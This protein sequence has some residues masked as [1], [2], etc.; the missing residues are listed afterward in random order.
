MAD[1]L[2][3]HKLFLPPF[4]PGLSQGQTG[5]V[6]GTN[7]GVSTVKS[8]EKAWCVPRI[9]EVCLWGKPG[10]VPRPTGPKS[11]FSC[12]FFLPESFLVRQTC[13]CQVIQ[14]ELAVQSN[15][16]W[17]SVLMGLDLRLLQALWIYMSGLTGVRVIGL[18]HNSCWTSALITCPHG[19][20]QGGARGCGTV[21]R[22]CPHP[23]E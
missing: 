17:A 9:N 16:I 11:V 23:H 14:L 15:P 19:G 12:A 1:Q 10:V 6:P 7:W 2:L 22:P 4:D 20:Q 3:T 5:F 8:K 21:P 18:Q 13:H